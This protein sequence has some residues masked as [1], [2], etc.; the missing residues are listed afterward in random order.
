[1]FLD[2][3]YCSFYFQVES[4]LESSIK[5]TGAVA[6]GTA[7]GW[8]SSPN[9]VQMGVACHQLYVAIN[10]TSR[11]NNMRGMAVHSEMIS[12]MGLVVGRLALALA[13]PHPLWLTCWSVRFMLP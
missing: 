11:S 7:A 4:F 2:R 3:S 13:E 1:M 5:F 12:S 6:T 10:D 8:L 9:C